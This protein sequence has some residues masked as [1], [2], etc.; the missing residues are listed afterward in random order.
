MPTWS[1]I[2]R[3]QH[4]S[5]GA[6]AR[7]R[8]TKATIRPSVS[9]F[10]G[11]VSASATS[12]PN[13]DSR[14]PMISSIPV[15]STM[16]SA[17]S[18]VS[19]ST[20]AGVAHEEVVDDELLHALC[21]GHGGEL[22]SLLPAWAPGGTE[23]RQAI[24]GCLELTGVAPPGT[25]PEEQ[26]V[27]KAGRQDADHRHVVGVGW[28]DPPGGAADLSPEAGDGRR[29]EEARR[30]DRGLR[31]DIPDPPR[32][33]VPREAGGVG[34]PVRLLGTPQHRVGDQP[35]ARHASGRAS[36]RGR[37][38]CRLGGSESARATTSGSRYGNRPSTEWAISIRSPCAESR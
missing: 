13:S 14:N 1:R 9:R 20:A 19:S 28:R 32:E 4:A 3:P 31:E 12:I 16:P 34:G 7:L 15:E 27:E 6:P 24:D 10:S 37:A 18:E 17:M 2:I 11:V 36:H 26:L 38:A 8:S 23:P 33:R 35:F 5:P 25:L 30:G 22:A 29:V 21:A